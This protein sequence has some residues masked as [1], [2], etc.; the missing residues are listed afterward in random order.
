MLQH[1]HNQF[2]NA[3]VELTSLGRIPLTDNLFWSILRHAMSV[4]CQDGDCT[5]ELL[6][7]ESV[8]DIEAGVEF[9]RL[10]A[11]LTHK[12]HLHGGA[13]WLGALH[14]TETVQT[15]KIHD[16]HVGFTLNITLLYM[17]YNMCLL[18]THKKVNLVI[19]LFFIVCIL[20]SKESARIRMYTL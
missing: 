18:Y 13:G 12:A 2:N 10:V 4:L 20:Y 6:D 5:G 17:C 3:V 9:E 19:M 11:A 1:H 14:G 15:K 8:Q 16:T 7:G